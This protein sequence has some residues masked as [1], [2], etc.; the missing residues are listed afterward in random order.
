MERLEVITTYPEAHDCDECQ[1]CQKSIRVPSRSNNC[2][3]CKLLF[4]KRLYKDFSSGNEAANEIIKNPI[5]ANKLNGLF[6]YEWI[7]W[8]RLKDISKIGQ[9][10]FGIIYKATWIDGLIDFATVHNGEMEYE[11]EGG[12]EVAIKFMKTS[13]R[14]YD[15]LFNEMNIQRALFTNSTVKFGNISK[16]YG[17][18]KNAQT[19][20]YGFVMEFAKHGDMRMYLSLNFESTRWRYKLPIAINIAN[21]LNLIHSVAMTHRDL[22][23][24]NILQYGESYI[25][26]GDLGLSQPSNSITTATEEKKIYGV[27]PYIPPEVLRGENFTTAGDIYSLGMLLWELATGISPFHDCSHDGILITAILDGKRPEIISPLIP[28]CY[29]QLIEKCWDNDPSNRPTAEEVKKRLN[30]IIGMYEAYD[31]EFTNESPEI[32][33]FLESDK[34]LKEMSNTHQIKKNSQTIHPGAVYTS[35]LLTAQ[36]VDFSTDFC[37]FNLK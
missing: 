28:V 12:T 11:R 36:I 6:Y 7:P 26:I 4:L 17:I 16:I 20:D 23:S 33:Q 18:T 22:H 13:L 25:E 35:R 21:G 19:L 14:N 1:E 30:E 32:L 8:E 34:L 10:G 9:G 2:S 27:I 37:S 3:A 31:D 15:E 24:G 29:I 5:C